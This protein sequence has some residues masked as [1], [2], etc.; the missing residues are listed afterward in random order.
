MPEIKLWFSPGACSLAPHILLHEIDVAF[1]AIATPIAQ[2]ANLT[3]DFTRLNPKQRVPVLSLDGEIVTELP[4]IA[5]A[6]SHLAPERGLMGRSAAEA[7]R[8]LEWM[9][10]LSGTLHGQGFGC[11]WRPARFSDDPRDF[12]NIQAK[13]ARTIRDCFAMIDRDLSAGRPPCV[14]TAVD[15]FLLV[16]YLWGN[17]IDLDMRTAYP[18]YAAFAEALADRES[19]VSALAAEG[20]AF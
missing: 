16:F 18:A 2:G 13:G 14:F 3:E 11:L 1:E 7:V 20:V 6:I 8:V 9:N 15:P 4:A 19:V 5:A 12:A 17:R 10:W